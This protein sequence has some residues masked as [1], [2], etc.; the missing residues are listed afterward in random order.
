MQS[1]S[2]QHCFLQRS[3]WGRSFC[4][5]N[6]GETYINKYIYIY[7][8]SIMVLITESSEACR[9]N[10][11]AEDWPSKIGN[12]HIYIHF[13]NF[14]CHPQLL[15]FDSHSLMMFDAVDQDQENLKLAATLRERYIRASSLQPLQVVPWC[16]ADINHLKTWREIKVYDWVDGGPVL[17]NLQSWGHWEHA[18]ALGTKR[19]KLATDAEK[20]D[21]FSL[22]WLCIFSTS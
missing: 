16:Q 14:L 11:I 17:C 10:W 15:L 19:W 7:F 3:L 18:G 4:G 8:F 5:N 12:K 9:K 2:S 20:S 21:L 13:V 6:N 22:Q 1:G